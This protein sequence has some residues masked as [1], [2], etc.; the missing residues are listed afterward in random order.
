MTLIS[1]N[2][3]K[4][5]PVPIEDIWAR[6]EPMLNRTLVRR[7]CNRFVRVRH[8]D[9]TARSK[10]RREGSARIEYPDSARTLSVPHS[11][12]VERT[13]SLLA[14]RRGFPTAGT[15]LARVGRQTS[16]W[17]FGNSRDMDDS[18]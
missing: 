9:R 7:Y 2:E 4:K 17:M 6:F 1:P 3:A 10:R 12:L 8:F 14:L 11:P 16:T 15:C 5:Q 13:I 18:G